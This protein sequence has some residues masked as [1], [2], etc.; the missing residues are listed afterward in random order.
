MLHL[1]PKALLTASIALAMFLFSCS[2]SSKIAGDAPKP[3]E[4]YANAQ[5]TPLVSS[6]AVPVTIVLDDLVR[7]LNT[8][9]SSK[10]L[11]EDFSYDDNGKDELMLSAWK[12]QDVT[13]FLS[14]N[15]I[16]YR[17]PVSLW[18][19]RRLM[20]G[21]AEASGELALSFKTNFTINPDWTLTT[22]TDVEY[23]EW[24]KQPVL[25]TGLGNIGIE[26]LAN[27]G[28]NRS[29]KTLAETLDRVVNQQL[30]LKPYVEEIWSSV[31]APVLMS[32]E[33][34][35][36]VKT[37][38][39]SI[40]MTPLT[41][42]TRNIRTTLQVQCHNDVN[43]GEK[44]A[45][46]EN[47]KVP[48]LV[49]LQSATDDFQMQFATDVPFPE[50]ER[51]AKG[52]MVG[53]VFES[54]KKKVRVDDI[55]IWGNNDRLIV[56]SQL[57]GA[58]NGKI[59]FMGKPRYNAAKNAVEVADLDFHLDTKNFL[60]KSASWM[61]QGPIKKQM[62]AAMTFPLDENIAELKKSVQ[63][64]LNRYEIAPGVILT[65]TLDEVKVLDTR[66]N[67]TGIRVDIYSKGKVNVEVK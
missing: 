37:T 17:V 62:A 49:Q 47:T 25:K 48:N 34:K 16:K 55:K 24:I 58:F 67:A 30:S 5:E 41:T 45:F 7:S 36:W 29:K 13:M 27:L 40:G 42:D 61:F 31:Q 38:P 44:P 52:M 43:F 22:K 64:T 9:L 54:G 39:L 14:G 65:G 8:S 12:S 66:L 35:M 51:L 63:E 23:H 57:S 6:L 50:A 46:R 26:T 4:L 32:D 20:V 60:H 53:Q 56:L 59:Y 33:Y 15:T 19:K 10:A 18:I 3:A 2:S 1:L 21:E 11:Y 28:L